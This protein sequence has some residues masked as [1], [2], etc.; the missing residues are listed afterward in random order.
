MNQQATKQNFTRPYTPKPTT[1]S[2][3]VQPT[4]AQVVNVT[5]PGANSRATAFT[6]ATSGVVQQASSPVAS[7]QAVAPSALAP[8]DLE[9]LQVVLEMGYLNLKQVTKRFFGIP[10]MLTEKAA[11]YT[12]KKLLTQGYLK[13]KDQE[14]SERTLLTS[15]QKA[16]ELIAQTYPDKKVPQYQ[17]SIFQPRVNHDLLLNDLR[18]RF[19]ELG[20]LN[21]WVSEKMLKEIPFLSRQFQDLPDAVCKKKNDKGYFLELEVSMKSPKVY[22][23]R[24]EE[25]LKILSLEEIEEAE[26]EG[27]VFFCTDEKVRDKIKEQIPENAKNISVLLYSNYFKAKESN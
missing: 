21:K 8:K 4:S 18:F 6:S 27:A 25:Y 5:A 19:E 15:T 3:V 9:I 1:T 20:F 11:I 16:Q 22:R 7:N 13:T 12:V 23:D 24:I 14:I 26:I 10:S 17:K 2:K